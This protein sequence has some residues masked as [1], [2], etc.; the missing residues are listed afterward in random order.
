MLNPTLMDETP[1]FGVKFEKTLVDR[2]MLEENLEYTIEDKGI[3]VDTD[4]GKYRN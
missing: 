3:S 2:M 4:K 1:V